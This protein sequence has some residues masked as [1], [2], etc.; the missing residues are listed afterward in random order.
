MKDDD[1]THRIHLLKKEKNA[2]ILAHNYQV[3]EIH[4]VADVI[5]DSL[6]LSLKARDT[7]ADILVVCGVRFMAETARILNPTRTVLIPAPDAGC[8]LADFLTPELILNTRKRYPGAAVVVYINST[9]SCKAVADIICTSGNAVRVVR[10][11]PN[12]Q[13]LFGPDANLAGYVSRQLPDKEIIALPPEGHCYVHTGFTLDDVSSVRA[14]GG[15]IIAHP[16]CPAPIQEQAD[17][18]ISTGK[19][20]EVAAGTGPWHIFTEKGMVDRLQEILP[21]QV[22]LGKE[23]AICADMKKITLQELLSC[24]EHLSGEVTIDP[25]ILAPARQA[26]DRMLAVP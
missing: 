19:M 12:R 24:L 15:K 2:V 6:E 16:E 22:F 8:P 20:A 18:V 9:A 25:A 1:L 13:I 5:G 4:D 21:E 17:H 10:S 3:P 11:L 14:R 23:D 26:L 7:T